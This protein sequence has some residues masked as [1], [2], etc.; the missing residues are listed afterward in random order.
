MCLQKLPVNQSCNQVENSISGQ[1]TGNVNLS[2]TS[3]NEIFCR[4]CQ[5]FEPEQE[6]VTP[7]LCSGTLKYIHQSCLQRWI[8]VQ[9]NRFCELCKYGFRMKITSKPLREWQKLEMSTMER[10]KIICS[11]IFHIIA[12]TCV[13]WSLY[14]LIER[15][16]EEIHNG[17]MEWPL[18]TKLIVVAI[19]FIGGVV[20]MYV[21][22]RMY[23]S[24][25]RKWHIFNRTFIV[26]NISPME[27]LTAQK[28]AKLKCENYQKNVQCE[29][30]LVFGD[31]SIDTVPNINV[32][33]HIAPTVRSE[34]FE[35]S[36]PS[37]TEIDNS[38]GKMFSD[39][40]DSHSRDVTDNDVNVNEI[41]HASNAVVPQRTFDS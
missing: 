13:I 12:L 29:R 22:C 32:N 18:W 2:V 23:V 33:L 28:E 11:V 41:R 10:R 37:E 31:V 30:A 5:E 7:C 1:S 4:F 25:C 9:D 36:S 40:D 6:L 14:V 16:T 26:Q 8:K 21:Q 27:L 3:S 19:G 39:G 15:T 38:H 35:F 34:E 24:L 17:I 20:F